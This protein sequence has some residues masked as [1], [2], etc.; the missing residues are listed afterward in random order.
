MHVVI[1]RAKLHPLSNE[2][3][4][5]SSSVCPAGKHAEN[6]DVN[7][8]SAPTHLDLLLK[9]K[10][11]LPATIILLQMMS[12]AKTKILSTTGVAQKR[13]ASH[14][15][16][17]NILENRSTHSKKRFSDHRDYVKR[18]ITTE[19]SGAHFSTNGHNVS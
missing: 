14:I 1:C 18:G 9:S 17:V 19:P 11:L 16:N 15:Q 10:E 12:T 8:Q 4:T 13:I 2:R 5:R 3:T 6:I 7:V